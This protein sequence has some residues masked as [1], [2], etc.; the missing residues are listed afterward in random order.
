[1]KTR[2]SLPFPSIVATALL[3]C[4][5]PLNASLIYNFNYDAGGSGTTVVDASGF[6]T[7]DDAISYDSTTATDNRI[8]STASTVSPNGGN[9]GNFATD[10]RRSLSSFGDKWNDGTTG[11]GATGEVTISMLLRDV[12]LTGGTNVD[13]AFFRTDNSGSPLYFA[14]ASTGTTTTALQLNV[15]GANATTSATA[16]LSNSGGNGW[17][18]LAFTYSANT[19]TG[20]VF[21]GRDFNASTGTWGSFGQI[22]SDLSVSNA[23]PNMDLGAAT[24]AG[25]GT[26]SGS[27]QQFNGD[28]FRIYNEVLTGAELE[29]LYV[30]PEP[31]T[32]A[33]L[34]GVLVLGLAVLRRRLR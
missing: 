7:Q 15:A 3:T 26:S 12:N 4:T 30:V 8:A 17:I 22:G 6:G 13:G 29:G 5:V 23:I 19:S 32:F 27:S 18:L 24:R 2:N 34:A 31:S 21:L 20:Q 33:L 1:M 25:F 16:D 28:D 9:Y 10:D 14:P 11:P